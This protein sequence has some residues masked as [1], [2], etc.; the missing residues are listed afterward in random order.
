MEIHQGV[1]HEEGLK[2]CVQLLTDV[3]IPDPA[4][5]VKA[6]PHLFSGGMRQRAVIAMGLGC[7][8]S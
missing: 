7:I 6:Y 3:K 1:S 2:K 5:R 4:A 8:P